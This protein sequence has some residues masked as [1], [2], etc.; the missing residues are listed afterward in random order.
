MKLR[1]YRKR[2]S[3]AMHQWIKGARRRFELSMCRV[4]VV[5]SGQSATQLARKYKSTHYVSVRES[6]T[7]EQVEKIRREATV[8]LD[9]CVLFAHSNNFK[10]HPYQRVIL[11]DEATALAGVASLS[12][13]RSNLF[14]TTKGTNHE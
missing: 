5:G 14:L 9:T 12:V 3:T 13:L 2:T 6:F 1:Q 4:L 11:I 10:S 7:L 8:H